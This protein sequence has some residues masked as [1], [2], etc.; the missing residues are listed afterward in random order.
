MINIFKK[1]KA[2]V[3]NMNKDQET[4]KMTNKF[5]KREILEIITI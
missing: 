2:S 1:I 4:T 5:E 3:D